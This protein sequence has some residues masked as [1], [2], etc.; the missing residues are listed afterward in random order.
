VVP[1][2]G[3]SNAK[4]VEDGRA[5]EDQRVNKKD[6]TG[7]PMPS[8]INIMTSVSRALGHMWPLRTPKYSTRD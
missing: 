8:V 5:R 1:G 3:N 2:V 6:Q 7:G 4:N